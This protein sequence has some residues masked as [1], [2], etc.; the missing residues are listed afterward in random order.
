MENIIKACVNLYLCNTPKLP[1]IQTDNIHKTIYCFIILLY[2]VIYY[3]IILF[4][5]WGL[6]EAA[7]LVT[8]MLNDCSN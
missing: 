4:P 3:I 2:I 7:A 6:Q 8:Q 5:P 1:V